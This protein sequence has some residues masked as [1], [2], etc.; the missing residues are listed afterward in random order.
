MPTEMLTDL[1]SSNT[2]VIEDC[3]EIPGNPTIEPNHIHENLS[4]C[5]RQTPCT[6]QSCLS[7]SLPVDSN[8]TLCT[9]QNL[10]WKQTCFSCSSPTDGNHIQNLTTTLNMTTWTATIATK[11]APPINHWISALTREIQDAIL[12]N[13]SVDLNSS[14]TSMLRNFCLNPT[15][16][17]STAPTYSS[18]RT[19]PLR[20][21]TSLL[22]F[23]IIIL[24][25][26]LLQSES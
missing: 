18:P 16:W 5:T 14:P 23:P 1:S 7:F 17:Y 10:C 21:S 2:E 15:Y 24:H 12:H 26:P 13:G 6:K 11:P 8:P 20:L 9:S 4:T 19:V 3:S 25:L 22:L